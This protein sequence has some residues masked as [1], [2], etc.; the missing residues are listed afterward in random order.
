M[1]LIK[2]YDDGC[3]HFEKLQKL[4]LELRQLAIHSV[5]T[6]A[7]NKQGE[8]THSTNDLHVVLPY[9]LRVF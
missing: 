4:Y 8:M 9:E 7:I 6:P 1:S 2:V 5:L 3:Q